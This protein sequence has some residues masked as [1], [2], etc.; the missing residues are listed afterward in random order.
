MPDGA[1][2]RVNQPHIQKKII[3][4]TTRKSK[5]KITIK[6]VAAQASGMIGIGMVGIKTTGPNSRMPHESR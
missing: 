3:I 4:V 6:K 2:F 5:G 1:T